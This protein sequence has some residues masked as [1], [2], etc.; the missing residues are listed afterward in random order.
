ML[1]GHYRWLEHVPGHLRLRDKACLIVGAGTDLTATIARVF[2][3]EGCQI[4]VVDENEQAMRMLVELIQEEGGFATSCPAT[5]RSPE[6]LEHSL[7]HLH[8]QQPDI[9]IDNWSGR[10]ARI[11]GLSTLPPVSKG[12]AGS[13]PC[14]NWL[15]VLAARSSDAMSSAPPSKSGSLISDTSL[16]GTFARILAKNG[17]PNRVRVNTV[18]FRREPKPISREYV[19]ADDTGSV[20]EHQPNVDEASLRLQVAYAALLLASDEASRVND[21]RI[22]IDDDK[23]EESLVA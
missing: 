14:R 16:T 7:S 20:D 5:T 1:Q 21:A 22:S 15:H 9:L 3:A 12:V 2:A 13:V 4:I 18:C 23:S 6:E 17:A 19:F 8:F 10:T 11:D